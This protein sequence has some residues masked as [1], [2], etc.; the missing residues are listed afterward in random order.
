MII[1]KSVELCW[2]PTNKQYY[3]DLGYVFTR[4]RE[5][6]TI[7]IEDLQ[8]N[9]SAKITIECDYCKKNIIRKYS[10]HQELHIQSLSKK[11][12]CQ[13][14]GKLKQREEADI[15]QK[16][17]LLSR[18]DR[19]YWNYKENRI[20]ELIKYIDTHHSITNMYEKDEPLY[21]AINKYDKSL[22]DLITEMG[23][24][25]ED[26]S[27]VNPYNLYSD[28]FNVEREIRKFINLHNRFPSK[29]EL[30]KDLKIH[31]K[32]IDYHG[33]MYEIKRKMN[34]QTDKDL[35]DNNGFW[36]R[37]LLEF[38]V[39]QF[40][41]KNKISF[42]REKFPFPKNEGYHRS[43]FYIETINGIAYHVEVWGFSSK[44]HGKLSRNY[45]LKKDK[46]LELYEKYK[47][48]LI[49]ISYD[50]I[51]NKQITFIQDYFVNKFST[52]KG[53]ELKKFDD[54]IYY[55]PKYMSDEEI[56]NVLLQISNNTKILPTQETVRNQNLNSLLI[57]IRQRH[58]SYYNFACKKNL[59]LQT[60]KHEWNAESIEKA[61]VEIVDNGFPITLKSLEKF[62][63]NGMTNKVNINDIKLDFYEKY[64]NE[65]K[66]I[67][68]KDIVF[69]EN[70]SKNRG[71]N[72]K[73]KFT[74]A[75]NLLAKEILNRLIPIDNG[76]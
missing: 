76:C 45:S 72:I 53:I 60:I 15:K 54:E 12:S 64:T 38:R 20:N 39:A 52:I 43:D 70:V 5:K 24:S 16:L 29:D 59:E 47:L 27:G 23:F 62:K 21:L 9:S 66:S 10:R 68:Q 7:K 14:C 63:F 28:F 56:A 71:A 46:K 74:K 48:N 75:Q 4:F 6:F 3:V 49:S 67:S 37:S 13:N 73:N 65:N 40:L 35:I 22:F 57:E 19:Y 42:K 36:N 69:L 1:T 32:S 44:N 2:N 61:F 33:G 18:S 51:E 17:N 8:P 34:Y 11:D 26:L 31:Q 55:N 25:W 58:G 41:I 50:D 30:T